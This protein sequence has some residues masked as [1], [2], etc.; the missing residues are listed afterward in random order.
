MRQKIGLELW[1]GCVKFC[2]ASV[3]WLRVAERPAATGNQYLRDGFLFLLAES[4]H[5]GLVFSMRR[6]PWELLGLEHA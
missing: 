2:E 1:A 4:H 3:D 5:S 6:M